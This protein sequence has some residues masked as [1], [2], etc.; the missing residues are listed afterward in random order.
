MS[1][2]TPSVT[3]LPIAAQVVDLPTIYPIGVYA[4]HGIAHLGFHLLSLDTVRGYLLQIDPTTNNTCVLNPRQ[5]DEFLDATG[6]AVWCDTLWIARGETI[7]RCADVIQI[8]D[9]I[10]TLSPGQYLPLQ[11]FVTLPYTANGVAVWESTVYVTCQKA[12]YIFIFDAATGR[13]ITRFPAPGVGIENIAVRDEELWICDTVEQSVYCLERA[14]GNVIFNVL[15]PFPDPT[16]LGFYPH[17]QLQE[18][19]LYVAY[20]G[21]EPYI[22]DNPNANP[23]YELEMRDRTFIHPLYT[24]LYADQSYALSNGY[25][26]EMSYVEELQPLE[27]VDVE[28]LEWRIAL[29]A[30]T[31]RQKVHHVEAIGRPF[32][33]RIDDGQRVAVFRFDNLKPGERHIFGWRALLEVWS[34][35][36]QFTPRQVENLPPLAPDLQARYLVDDDDLAMDT[37]VI[38]RAA[39]EAVGTETNILRQVYRIRNYVYDRL[40]YAIKPYIDTPD[41]VLERGTGS[42]GEY[43][44]VLLALCRLNGIA[45]RT[46]GRYK[47]PPYPDRRNLPLQPDFNHVWMEFYLPGVGW[48]PMESNPDDVQERGPYPARFFMG[49]A[50][51]HAEVGKGISF[52]NLRVQGK[53]VNRDDVSIGNLALNHIRFRILK[54]LKPV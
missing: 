41:V 8:K 25:L 36:Y 33:E 22:R 32:E 43:L 16:G 23:T 26:V 28:Q 29:P 31:D 14:T 9:G 1:S 45:C 24:K 38:R 48:L 46:V 53:P 15:T 42:C 3:A 20:A 54:E 5:T 34:I 12:G 27:E 18:D 19:V 13:E 21:L 17:P 52:E 30:E 47:C 39:K 35:K 7:Y 51:Y 44:G 6:L 4:L 37:P 10:P 40:S 50:W 2:V 11:P 49:L